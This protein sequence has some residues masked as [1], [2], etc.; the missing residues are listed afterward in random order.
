VKHATFLLAASLCV[1]ACADVHDELSPGP[2]ERVAVVLRAA[3]AQVYR[4]RAADAPLRHEWVF[5]APD[6]DLY[7]AAGRRVGRH[8]AG[9]TW[10]AMDGSRV[11][12]KVTGRAPAR[13]EDSI[14][15]LK[16]AARAERDG[17]FGGVTMIQRLDTVGGAPPRD[18]CTAATVGQQL[19]VPYAAQ[20][21]F[22]TR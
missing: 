19:R 6:A 3:G 16:L 1:A 14:P 20:Y 8:F 11:T 4:C 5:V 22:F 21:V 18:G 17:L 13:S 12:A 9:P 2:S 15:W 7:D 10:E